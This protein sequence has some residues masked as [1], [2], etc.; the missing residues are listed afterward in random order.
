MKKALCLFLSLLMMISVFSVVSLAVDKVAFKEVVCTAEGVEL[1]WSD[2]K[3]V[4]NYIIYRAD[5]E[6]GADFVIATTT[7]NKYF[8]ADVTE[9]ESYTYK[10]VAQAKDGS[11]T[12]IENADAFTLVFV[13]KVCKHEKTEWE[14]VQPSSVYSEGIQQEVCVSCNEVLGFK[15]VTRIAPSTPAIKDLYN[16]TRGV[17]FTWTAVEGADAYNVYR[18]SAGEVKWVLLT[19]TA[20]TGFTDTTVE[21]GK[22]YKYAVRAIN[23]G[24]ISPYIGGRVIK[25]VSAPTG[26]TAA[27]TLG[28]IY[29]KWDKLD[30]I[31]RFNVYR[32][33]V[34]DANW[35]YLGSTKNNYYPDLK[36]EAD[37]D[38]IYVVRAI[39]SGYY[40]NYYADNKP[41]KR[42]EAPKLAE[43]VSSADGITVSWN[44]VDGADGCYVYRKTA[45]SSWKLIGNVKGTKS[46]AYLDKST[47]KGVTYTY[48]VR[49]YGDSSVSWYYVN[50][51]SC[52]DAH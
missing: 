18:R 7:S 37:T 10:I 24:G 30:N 6:T 1:S 48:T 51:I 23:D 3:D 29:V 4:A 26:L 27:N 41:L 16:S 5:G 43:C 11:Y 25:F 34:G 12:D 47:Q 36:I 49:A 19:S 21:N 13:K 15:D 17:G 45:N 8:D 44:W 22:Y 20:K 35:T 32:K 40:S 14:V 50:G 46:N 42:L 39:S 9:G 33:V 38:Y 28:G 31:D 2:V 52:K